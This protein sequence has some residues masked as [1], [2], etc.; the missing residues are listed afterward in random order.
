MLLQVNMIKRD[1]VLR[2]H[3]FAISNLSDGRVGTWIHDESKKNGRSNIK[4]KNEAEMFD[5]L[6]KYYF[7]SQEVKGLRICDIFDEW[8]DYKTKKKNNKDETKKQNISSYVK[9]LQGTKIDQMKLSC[10]TTID[11]EEW[12]IDIL[13][14]HRMNAKK[15]NTNKIVV[16]GPLVYAKRKNI[17]LENPWKTEE[18]EYKHLLKSPRIKPSEQMVFYPDEIDDLCKEFEN[19]YL[20]NANV[21][22]LGLMS[23]FDLGLRIG[24]LC[25]LK[26]SDVNWANESIFIQRQEDSSGAV[27]DYVKSDSSAGYRELDLSDNVI[28]IFKRIKRDS[29]ILSEFIFTNHIGERKI[30]RAFENRLTKAE[31]RLGWNSKELKYSHCIR[32]TVASRMSISGFS[33]EEIRRWLG[34]TNKETTLKYIYN[35]FR[36]SETKKKVKMNAILATNHNCLQ[37]SSKNESILADKKMPEAL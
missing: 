21:T 28:S 20:Y 34:H 3:D 25:A 31:L 19:R 13:R 14:E 35:P 24:E 1:K 30:K 8:L 27:E 7:N 4:A 2:I 22:N 18:L 5:K 15:F 12:A 23:N 32:R 6:Y 17:I 26:W 33:L 36:S 29:P 16:T 37:L 9:Y 10:I 11:L